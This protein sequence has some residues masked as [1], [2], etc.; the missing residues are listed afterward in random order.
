MPRVP[1]Y[2]RQ[3]QEGGLPN[4]RFTPSS[5]IESFGGG[6]SFQQVTNAASQFIQNKMQ[7]ADDIATTEAYANAV[8]VKNDLIYNPETGAMTRT[9]KNAIGSVES[10]TDQYNSELDNIGKG[11]ANDRQRMAF[12]KIRLQQTSELY[13]TL[14]RHEFQEHAKYDQETTKTAITVSMDDAIKNY[15]SPG[16]ISESIAT[17]IDAIERHGQRSGLPPETIKQQK[18]RAVS[19]THSGIIGRMLDNGQDQLAKAYYEEAKKGITGE[20][21]SKIEKSLEV[22]T[23]RGESQRKTDDIIEKN[24]SLSDSLEIARDINDPELRDS[25]VSRIKERFSEQKAVQDQQK[26]ARYQQAANILEDTKDK[27]QIPANIW[28]NLTLS[29]RNALDS[30]AKQLAS[31]EPVSTDWKIYYDLKTAASFEGTRNKFLRENL[32]QYRS[33]LAEGEFKELINLQSSIRSGQQKAIDSLSGYR[34]T[35]MIVNDTL[36]DIGIDPTPKQGSK[37][38]EKVALL[39]RRVDQEI[40]DYAERNNGKKPSNQE[41]QG[42]LDNLVV[43]GE[44]DKFFYNPNKFLFEVEEGDIFL[45]DAKDIP[46]TERLKIEEALRVNNMPVTEDIVIDL[47]NRKIQRTLDNAN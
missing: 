36:N 29:E 23:L 8:K 22:G 17:Q 39:K 27:D 16:K 35:T 33:K 2:S 13:S 45:I 24:L 7:E 28:A 37:D 4:A 6:Q 38:A 40:A 18:Q 32:L 11:L 12:N 10:Y 1:G 46:R 30:R 31:G 14:Q 25:V 26:L 9:G 34:T 3:I 42:I 47:Y 15:Q 41:I 19:A 44:V 43:K 21:A 20:D 5:N